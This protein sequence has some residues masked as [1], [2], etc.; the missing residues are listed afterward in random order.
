VLKTFQFVVLRENTSFQIAHEG[1]LC[2]QR[3]VCL[4]ESQALASAVY[5]A[6]NDGTSNFARFASTAAV[7]P[8]VLSELM[9]LRK[10]P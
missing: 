8:T 3:E 10:N 2:V 7:A 9:I 6:D 4:V 5:L 1:A